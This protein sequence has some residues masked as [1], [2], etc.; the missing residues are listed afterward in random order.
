MTIVEPSTNTEIHSS[1]HDSIVVWNPW[2]TGSPAFADLEA[3]D[4]LH[5]LCVETALT[6]GYILEPGQQHLLQQTIV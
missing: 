2:S 3:G 1:G 4:Y 6:Q 5:F